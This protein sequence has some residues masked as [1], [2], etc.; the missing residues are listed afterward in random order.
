M[1]PPVAGS[2]THPSSFSSSPGAASTAHVSSISEAPSISSFVSLQDKRASVA[3]SS[4]HSHLNSPPSFPQIDLPRCAD[5][6]H[7]VPSYGQS[8]PIN[9]PLKPGMRPSQFGP[10]PVHDAG[11][12]FGT[13]YGVLA[14]DSPHSSSSLR[15]S[16]SSGYAQTH[17]TFSPLST[18]SVSRTVKFPFLVSC[19]PMVLSALLLI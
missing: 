10:S 16:D 13:H 6:L 9:I 19:F 17:S 18:V 14:Q 11:S 3:S 7:C 4:R 15:G 8:S 1:P 2:P 5:S 12:C